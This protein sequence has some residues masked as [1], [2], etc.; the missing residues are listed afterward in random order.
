MFTPIG[1]NIIIDPTSQKVE[2]VTES[3]ID[4]GSLEDVSHKTVASGTVESVGKD[5]LEVQVGD[6]V[7]Y[8][9]HAGHSF[10]V[11][12]KQLLS[13]MEANIIGFQRK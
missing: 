5:V 2:N 1:K 7:I 11:S 10:E 3:G 4:L 13:V 8:E 9:I 6:K 12:G